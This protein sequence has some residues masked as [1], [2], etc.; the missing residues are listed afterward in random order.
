MCIQNRRL[1]GEKR[2]GETDENENSI[3]DA[4]EREYGTAVFIR[5]VLR[6]SAMCT[7]SWWLR[8]H[9]LL[10]YAVYCEL[11]VRPIYCPVLNDCGIGHGKVK[12]TVYVKMLSH[13][14]PRLWCWSYSCA[15]GGAGT[16]S[17]LRWRKYFRPCKFSNSDRKSHAHHSSD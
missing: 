5:E 3:T 8:V 15:G 1:R 17:T 6:Q 12:V 16:T 14:F 2:K 9:F 10:C 13:T 7:A 11:Q 4:H